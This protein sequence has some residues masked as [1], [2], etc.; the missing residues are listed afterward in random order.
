[1]DPITALTL[2]STSVQ[3]AGQVKELLDKGSVTQQSLETAVPQI[4]PQ[5]ASLGASLFPK[6]AP[7]LQAVAAASA[8]FDPNVTKWLQGSLNKLLTPSPNLE[9]DGVYGPKTQEAVEAAQKQL[10]IPVDGWAGEVTQGAIIAALTK[11]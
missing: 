11:H 10:G 1:M 2:I 6:V 4:V 7:E 9:V 3:V 5:L 8:T